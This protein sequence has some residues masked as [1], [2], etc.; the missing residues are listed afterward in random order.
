[1]PSISMSPRSTLRHGPHGSAEVTPCALSPPSLVDTSL[2]Y[3]ASL[4]TSLT[5]SLKLPIESPTMKTLSLGPSFGKLQTKKASS[6][7]NLDKYE[8]AIRRYCSEPH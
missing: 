7:K 4:L 1:M 6:M 8:N 3:I 5:L 2:G